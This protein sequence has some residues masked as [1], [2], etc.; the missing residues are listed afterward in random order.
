MQNLKGGG[1]PVL[2]VGHTVLK[3]RSITLKPLLHAVV[4]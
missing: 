2:Y 4:G 3:S 1:T